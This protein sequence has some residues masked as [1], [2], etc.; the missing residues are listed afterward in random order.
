MAQQIKDFT[1]PLQGFLE[2]Y[3]LQHIFNDTVLTVLGISITAVILYILGRWLLRQLV[4]HAIYSTAK[5]HDWRKSDIKKRETTLKALF[6]NIWR[7][8]VLAYFIGAMLSQVF[9]ID[10]APLFA[11]A[12]V[13]GVAIGFGT[14]SLIK[15]F[16]SG[17][18]IVAENQYRVGDIIELNNA[19]GTVE[20]IGIRSTIIRDNTG[21]VHYFPNGTVAHVVNKTMGYGMARFSLKLAAES[22][23]NA[24]IAIINQL[25]EALAKE[26]DWHNKIIT[27][28]AFAYIDNIDSDSVE[29]VITGKTQAADQWAVAAEMRRRILKA[30]QEEKIT[31]AS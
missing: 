19:T 13:L 17:V 5:Y 2:R 26:P 23:M 27:P 25:G 14:Q 9:H 15:D 30:F 6:M 3:H 29:I 8:C 20:R 24:A 1:G 4:N 7:I 22:D 10:L 28:P 18:F 12:S 11:S 31:L 21:A 16:L